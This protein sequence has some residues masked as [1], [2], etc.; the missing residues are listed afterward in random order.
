MYDSIINDVQDY[1]NKTVPTTKESLKD[2]LV[3]SMKLTQ[4]LIASKVSAHRTLLQKK[5]KFRQPQDRGITDFDRKIM[6]DNDIS[7]EIYSFEL[8]SELSDALSAR[9][10][11]LKVLFQSL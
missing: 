2:A 5:E 11:L 6:L 4:P 3:A 9:A 1:L 10:E 7:E 8:L